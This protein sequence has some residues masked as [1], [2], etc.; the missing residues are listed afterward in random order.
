[1]HYALLR[2]LLFALDPE[3]AHGL[4]LQAL[5][6]THALGLSALVAPRV[7]GT[8]VRAMGIDFPNAVGLAAGMDK[9]GEHIDALAALGFGFVEIGTVTPRPQPGNPRPRM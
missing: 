8:P 6:K 2:P 5:E 7:T 1:M 9:N 4:T 3:R